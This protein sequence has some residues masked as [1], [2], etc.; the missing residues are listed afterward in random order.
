MERRNLVTTPE[1]AQMLYNSGNP[2][3]R[4]IALLS[5]GTANLR[6]YGSEIKSFKDA[7]EWLIEK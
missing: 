1:L 3:L 4:G 7:L 5:V 6:T 2:A